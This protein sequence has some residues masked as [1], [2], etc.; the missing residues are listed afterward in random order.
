MADHLSLIGAGPHRIRGGS[1]V[2]KSGKGVDDDR[3][4]GTRLARYDIK[5][6]SKLNPELIDDG[7]TFDAQ[8]GQHPLPFT[9]LQ[10]CLSLEIPSRRRFHEMHN[11]IDFLTVTTSAYSRGKPT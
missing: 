10:L 4:A 11:M 2:H 1:R 5:T 8:I 7:K 6:F 3:F 9:P